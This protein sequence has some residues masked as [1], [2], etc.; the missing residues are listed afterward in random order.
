MKGINVQTD[1][2]RPPPHRRK[3][4]RGRGELAQSLVELAMVAPVLLIIVLGVIDY[5]RVYFSY[6]SVTNAAR[7]GVDYAAL[8]CDPECDVEGIVS[9]VLSDTTDLP[10]ASPS[11]PQ[12]E[13]ATGT[14]AQGRAYAEVTTSYTFTTLFPWPG[15]PTSMNVER[16]VRARIGE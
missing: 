6:V 1:V 11:N 12:V 4:T 3:R 5:G 14:D 16:T 2:L 8:N 7:N 13:F 15:L 9:A 10:D